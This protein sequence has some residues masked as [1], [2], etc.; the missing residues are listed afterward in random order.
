MV[1]ET[2]DGVVLM[3]PHAAHER[4]LYEKYLAEVTGHHVSI[5]GLLTPETVELDPE[6]AL[7]V[8]ENMD[9]L[10]QMGFGI[11]EFGGDTFIVDALPACLGSLSAVALLNAVAQ[12]LDRGGERGGTERWAEERSAQAACKTAV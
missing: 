7:C 6:D 3:D 5:Q 10:K 9:M 11:S 8:R 2:E 12:S 4:V 1:L